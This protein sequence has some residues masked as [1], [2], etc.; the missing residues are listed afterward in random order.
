MKSIRPAVILVPAIVF[1]TLVVAGTVNGESFIAAL[2]ALFETIMI[3]GSWLVSIGVL[4]FVVFLIFIMAHP[5]GATKLGGEDAQPEYS[6]WNWFAISLCSG[7]GT[8]IVFWGPVEPLL[9][10][11]APQA[12]AGIVPASYEAVMW[13]FDKA[14]LHWSFAP[15][16]CYCV[17]GAIIAYAFWNMRAP[18]SVSSA[19]AP[20]LGRRSQGKRF[21]GV[22]DTLAVFALT[23]G[24]AGSLG[25]GLLQISSGLN[26]VFGVP[27]VPLT[28]IVLCA[29]IVAV[30]TFASITGVDRGIRWLADKNAWI[31][32]GLMILAFVFGPAQWI[33]NLLVESFGSFVSGFVESITAVAAFPDDGSVAGSVWAASSEMW[34]QWWDEY[35]FVDFLSFGAVVGLFSIKLA[36]GR[37]LRQYVFMNWVLP[38]LFG[39]VWFAI[40]GGLSLDIQY[41]YAAYADRVDLAGCASLY[42]YM[43]AY[44]NEAV[45]LKVIEA[46]PLSFILKPLMLLLVALSFITLADSMTSTISLMSLRRSDGVEEAPWGIKLMW[47]LVIG[48]AALV[49]TLTGSIDGIKIVKTIAGYPI[50]ILG[51]VAMICFV[52][53]LFKGRSRDLDKGSKGI[54]SAEG[55]GALEDGEST[56][57]ERS[58]EYAETELA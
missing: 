38:A 28:L 7:I 58:F 47:G 18:F 12:S 13:A 33:C 40:F 52:I 42:D 36:K 51:I 30:Y 20:L 2:N 24:V 46:I 32:L 16:A 41:N 3:N 10:T 37:T 8:G 31:F 5:V 17:F 19:F 22:V 23:G 50:L 56:V 53:A 14:Y 44:G 1:A 25:Y 15:Y 29:V 26:T 6:F 35:Y 49:F 43:L 48:G 11:E 57:C 34:P 39:I 27:D 21:K 54:G 4:A 55:G 9:F 45:M